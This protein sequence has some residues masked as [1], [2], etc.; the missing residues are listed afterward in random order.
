VTSHRGTPWF[1]IAGVFLVNAVLSALTG[2][3]ALAVGQVV[4]AA[5]AALAGVAVLLR[6]RR[7]VRTEGPPDA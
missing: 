6:P 2:V 7:A 4:T 5:L 3:P 1:V